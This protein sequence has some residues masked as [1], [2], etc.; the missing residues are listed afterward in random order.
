MRP[1][2]PPSVCGDLSAGGACL[3]VTAISDKLPL[4]SGNRSRHCPTPVA[5]ELP[6]D[7]SIRP[8]SAT[9]ADRAAVAA[10]TL[11]GSAQAQ[12]PAPLKTRNVVLIVSD[13]LRWQEIFTGADPTLL[14]ET[15]G[16]IW[17]K[18]AD[19]KK[20]VLARRRA[21]AAQGAVSLP[22]DDGRD[23]R[24]DLRQPDQGQHRTRHQRAG[25][26]L[27]RL[28]RDDDRASGPAHQFQRIRPESQHLGVRVAERSARTAA[29]ACAIFGTWAT[30]KDI[31]NVPRS[32]LPCAS[33]LIRPTADSSTPRAAPAEPPVRDHR[34]AR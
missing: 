26:L 17:A 23:A 27:P 8:A 14:D 25:L 2:A 5:P 13:G 24:A 29:A 31:F 7:H 20:R 3:V 30:F 15:H 6:D 1:F 11:V 33:D 4:T 18:P 19:L 28:Q 16:G 21:G 32:K 12:T 22:V 9:P 34:A 10:A